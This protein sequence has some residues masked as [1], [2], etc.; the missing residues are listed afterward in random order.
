MPET[1]VFR[2]SSLGVQS[3]GLAG[4]FDIVAAPALERIVADVRPEP[5]LVDVSA[6][7]FMDATV[8]DFFEELRVRIAPACVTVHGARGGVARLL[9]IAVDRWKHPEGFHVVPCATYSPMGVA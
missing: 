4:E 2:I 9:G 1:T 8:L 3:L 5:V 6:V 7:E